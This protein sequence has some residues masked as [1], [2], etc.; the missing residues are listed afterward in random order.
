MEGLDVPLADGRHRGV[1]LIGAFEDFV[2]DVGEVLNEGHLEAPPDQIPPKH[3]PVDVAAGMAQVAEV[4]DRHAAAVDA[5]FARCQRY[6]RL[7]AAGEGVGEPQGHSRSEAAAEA[8]ACSA[9]TFQ[10][11]PH[12][13]EECKKG[14]V[15]PSY[16]RSDVFFASAANPLRFEGDASPNPVSGGKPEEMP[17]NP[18]G[19]DMPPMPPLPGGLKPGG[20][21]PEDIAGFTQGEIVDFDPDQFAALPSDAMEGFKPGQ[22]E[23]LPPEVFEAMRPDQFKNLDPKAMEGFKPGQVKVLPPEVF[24]A[25][26]PGQFKNLDPKAMRGINANQIAEFDPALMKQF[27]P[28]QFQALPKDAFAGLKSNQIKRLPL[29]L[30]N[31]FSAEMVEELADSAISGFK[32][33]TFLS[34]NEEA[35]GALAGT[36]VAELSAKL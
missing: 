33:E 32:A 22:V 25:M 24:E 15:M 31:Y 6:E 2:V 27:E 35:I 5:R 1:L 17:P 10:D 7:G 16:R 26:R 8:T 11:A 28:N 4:V 34:L 23:V 20:A 29:D 30:M 18:V 14:D 13:F 3:I 21:R 36:Q 9:M 12:T 19:G